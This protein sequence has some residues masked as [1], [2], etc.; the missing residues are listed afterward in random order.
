MTPLRMAAGP[1]VTAGT[2]EP[3]KHVFSTW[4][5]RLLLLL[6]TA[7]FVVRLSPASAGSPPQDESQLLRVSILDVGQGDAILVQT[8]EGKTVLID[9][10]PGKSSDL[11]LSQLEQLGVTRLD[12]AFNTHPH[13][14]HLGGFV[15][16]LERYPVAMFVD[17][18]VPHTTRSYEN[19]LLALKSKQVPVR[20]A[21]RGQTYKVGDT[22]RFEV[23]APT[24]AW[25]REAGS[26]LNNTSIVLR[27]TYGRFSMLLTGD[28]ERPIEQHLLSEGVEPALVLKAGHH[29]SHSSSTPAF[30]DALHVKV[31]IISCGQ[32]NRYGHPHR[33]TLYTF[34]SRSILV[35][36]TDTDGQV[37]VLSDGDR[38]W[39]ETFPRSRLRAAQDG[40]APAPARVAGPWELAGMA[41]GRVDVSAGMTSAPTP[42]AAARTVPE[43][44]APEGGYVASAKSTVFHKATCRYA[45]RISPNNLRHYETRE[46]AIADGKTPAHCCNP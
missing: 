28:A 13:E 1:G 34:M 12:A 42:A 36:R 37:R 46:E 21:R 35:F 33:E 6:S 32:D 16:V 24:D 39:V 18:G 29:G 43:Q 3:M 9:A 20:T 2:G 4:T 25:I 44:A 26:H 45:K 10:G 27:L 41:S 7:L 23:L 11:L 8:P 17:S 5:G 30:V 38:L 14:D 40:Q 19:L 22:A 15:A 31:A